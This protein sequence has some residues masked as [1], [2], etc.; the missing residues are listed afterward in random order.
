MAVESSSDCG[1]DEGGSDGGSSG[2][3]GLVSGDD[4][5]SSDDPSSD[6]SDD[7]D[8]QIEQEF[9]NASQALRREDIESV[10]DEFTYQVVGSWRRGDDSYADTVRAFGRA[11]GKQFAVRHALS[12]SNNYKISQYGQNAWVLARAWCKRMHF[13]FEVEQTLLKGVRH[14][15]LDLAAHAHLPGGRRVRRARGQQRLR[16]PGRGGAG[17]GDPGHLPELR[18]MDATMRV[19]RRRELIGGHIV[20]RGRRAIGRGGLVGV[21]R[22][23]TRS[24][25]PAQIV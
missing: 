22:G 16:G 10:F 17:P 12:Q 1:G 9:D 4:P 6:D 8:D 18:V 3:P 13:F 20:R 21:H 15:A 25:T 19:Q 5:L 23:S 24:G 11:Q 14:D 2:P 7:D